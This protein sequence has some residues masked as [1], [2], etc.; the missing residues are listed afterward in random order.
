MEDI[1]SKIYNIIKNSDSVTPEQLM[2]KSGAKSQDEMFG[3]VNELLSEGSLVIDRRGNLLETEAAGMKCAV[4]TS[5]AENFGFAHPKEGEDI[6]VH[7]TQMKEALP[8]DRV[9]LRVWYNRGRGYEGEVVSI[10]E[11]GSHLETG[12]VIREN[13]KFVFQP[14]RA[15]RNNIP[16][17][18]A[19]EES[20]RR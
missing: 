1:K 19:E 10:L 9:L 15:Y 17:A 7:A 20:A 14:E 6:Y 2:E 18:A 4:M 5:F 16:I 8:G 3:A 13:G 12:R 11:S